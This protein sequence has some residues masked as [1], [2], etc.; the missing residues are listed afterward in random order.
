MPPATGD[1]LA[2]HARSADR[3]AALGAL[4]DWSAGHAPE[5]ALFVTGGLA[6][7]QV[8]GCGGI[9][10]QPLAARLGRRHRLASVGCTASAADNSLGRCV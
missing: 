4:T 6:V 2:L 3:H 9:S 7:A 8:V 1:D 5:V 10:F